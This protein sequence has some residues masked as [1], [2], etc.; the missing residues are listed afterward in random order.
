MR[1]HLAIT[2]AVGAAALLGAAVVAGVAR[3]DDDRSEDRQG[4]FQ[5]T[6]LVSN[7]P[8]LAK[9]TD[10]NTVNPW[11]AAF[12]P[13]EALWVADNGSH[14]LTVYSLNPK[15][16]PQVGKLVVKL[17]P[18]DNTWAPTGLVWNPSP[19]QFFLPN[20][21]FPATF[22]AVSEGGQIVG[23]NANANPPDPVGLSLATVIKTN[24][25]GVYKG[26]AFGTNPEGSFI[27]VTNFRAAKVEAYDTNFTEVTRFP[28]ID[29]DIPSGFAPFGIENICG[30]L[31]VTFAKQDKAKEDDVAGPGL[32]FVDVFTTSGKLVRRFATRGTLNA[33]WGLARAP[34]SFG[35]FGG[36]ILVGNFGDGKMNAFGNHGEFLGQLRA[37]NGKTITIDG[38][39]ALKFGGFKGAEPEDLY[40]T[41][42]I[43]DEKDG[44]IGDI[45]PV[46]GRN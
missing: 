18:Q 10:H 14:A 33:P 35:K 13:G 34:L 4:A 39:W 46:P 30:E 2:T 17:S 11:G 40:F 21:K 15:D 9:V 41:A 27:F 3:G 12:I 29:R 26:A 8:N 25:G 31:F 19:N 43:H 5:V 38:L 42:G 23:W 20:T 24:A 45:S 32:G 16:M 36:A 37:R 6:N 22:I 1:E 7:I 28:F 44:L